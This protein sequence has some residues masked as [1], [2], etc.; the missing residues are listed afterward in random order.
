MLDPNHPLPLHIQLKEEIEKQ[1]VEKRYQEKIPSERE[2]METYAVSRSTVREAVNLLVREGVLKKVHG[3]GTF[4]SIKPIQD[5]LG[6]LCS[7]TET[8][9]NMGMEPGAKVI[10]HYITTPSAHIRDL[11]GFQSAYF[12]KR[13]RFANQIPIGI[14]SHF[15]PVEIG[16]RLVQFQL[17]NATLYD[18]LENELHIRFGE[19]EQIITSGTI[20]G[21]DAK[22]LHAG[23][24]ANVLKVERIITNTAGEVIEYEE[25]H[26]RADMYSFRIKSSRK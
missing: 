20:T 4:I 15:Y 8:I 18:L 12:I 5:W 7:T 2:L 19:S 21:E 1:I 26:Y 16:E 24:H 9:R 23:D 25:A 13:I 3:K 10:E 6:N 22:H 11:T 17:D 14:E